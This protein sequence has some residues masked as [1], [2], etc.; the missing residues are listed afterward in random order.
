MP[1]LPRR[2]AALLVSVAV[3]VAGCSSGA[4]LSPLDAAEPVSTQQPVVDGPCPAERAGSRTVT[5]DPVLV[6]AETA[7]G[8]KWLVSADQ[9]TTTTTGPEVTTT[10]MLA[11]VVTTAAVDCRSVL[12]AAES[13]RDTL[14]SSIR[15]VE[16]AIAQIQLGIDNNGRS[17]DSAR[18]W[19][20]SVQVDYDHAVRAA[21]AGGGADTL[22]EEAARQ[23][24]RLADAKGIVAS[25]EA[26]IAKAH[27]DLS[28]AKAQKAEWER[29][30]GEAATT[31]RQASAGTC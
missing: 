12:R 26:L 28:R 23:E 21:E 5:H 24:T 8:W 17:L 4:D 9:G 18:R 20:A 10:T 22:M 7:S 30:L 27:G 13:Y 6:C 15:Q 2:A 16:G 11:T 1:L 3:L 19:A 25:W 14:Q 31:I 29:K